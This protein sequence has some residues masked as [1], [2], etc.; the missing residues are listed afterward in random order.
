MQ[1][2]IEYM[3]KSN[4]STLYN[5]LIKKLTHVYRKLLFSEFDLLYAKFN[6]SIY[7]LRE[8][9]TIFSIYSYP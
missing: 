7:N 3:Y 4:I 5:D 2:K 8:I 6:K 9:D 1:N